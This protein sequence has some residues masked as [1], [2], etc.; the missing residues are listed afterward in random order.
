MSETPA[1]PKARGR[2]ARLLRGTLRWVIRLGLLL[3]IAVM[4]LYLARRAVLER[5]L[6]DWAETLL[7]E[8]LDAE[9][10]LGSLGGNWV[11]TFRLRGV[12]IAGRGPHAL[13][14][15]D[16]AIDLAIS[17]DAAYAEDW[18]RLVHSAQIRAKRALVTLPDPDPAADQADPTAPFV[19]D[20]V[21]QV[22]E[23][24][25][26]GGVSVTV[27]DCAL[28]RLEGSGARSTDEDPNEDTG[29]VHRGALELTLS[30]LAPRRRLDL[31]WGDIRIDASARAATRALHAELS[32]PRPGE[33]AAVFV[34]LPRPLLGGALNATL[35]LDGR[36]HLDA[37]L[38]VAGVELVGRGEVSAD[39]AVTITPGDR[40]EIDHAAVRIPGGRIDARNVGFD[41]PRTTPDLSAFL[42]RFDGALD[43]DIPDCRRFADLLPPDVAPWLPRSG[44]IRGS[45]SEHALRLENGH[46]TWPDRG[47]TAAIRGGTIPFRSRAPSA[48]GGRFGLDGP[49]RLGLRVTASEPAEFALPGDIEPLVIQG[50]ADLEV[51]GSIEVWR[52]VGSVDL[53]PGSCADQSWV[54][55]TGRIEIDPEIAPLFDLQITEAVSGSHG[56]ALGPVTLTG[57]GGLTTS[58]FSIHV[59]VDAREVAPP[60]RHVDERTPLSLTGDITWSDNSLTGTDLV[61]S[62]PADARATFALD[63]AADTLDLD[64]TEL[65]VQ[66]ARLNPVFHAEWPV[67]RIRG[68]ART[69]GQLFD[70]QIELDL[71]AVVPEPLTQVPTE[72]WH[73]AL[74]V[75]AEDQLEVALAIERAGPGAALV[76]RTATAHFGSGVEFECSGKVPVGWDGT[77]LAPLEPAPDSEP[78]RLT[79][80]LVVRGLIPAEYSISPPLPLGASTVPDETA[81]ADPESEQERFAVTAAL[82]WG[83]E[84]LAIETIDI[85]GDVAGREQSLHGNLTLA[86]LTR[87]LV[88]QLAFGEVIP[89]G[90]LT[91]API[92][93]E[94]LP[95]VLHGLP[96]LTGRMEIDAKF[97]GSL[98][99]PIESASIR[100]VDGR[101][102]TS[103][104]V[105]TIEEIQ[106][107]VDIR[108]DG[109]HIGQA[110]GSLGAG[111]FSV[112]GGAS[113]AGG[114]V[115]DAISTGR[116]LDVDV[117]IEG[118]DL[119]VLRRTGLKLRADTDVRIHGDLETLA[120]EGR[121]ALSSGTL[122]QRFSLVPDFRSRGAGTSTGITLPTIPDPFGSHVKYDVEIVTD[123]PFAIF[124]HVV[125]TK[126]RA[127]ARL[128]GTG[129][130]PRIEGTA[131]ALDGVV[132]LPAMS[133][134]VQQALITFDPDRPRFPKLFALARGRRLGVDVQAQVEGSL[135]RM[136]VELSST[137]ALSSEEITVLLSTGR[138]P[139]DLRERGLQSQ[140]ALVG[141]YLA[142]ELVDFYLGSDTTERDETLLDRFSFESGREVSRNGVESITVEFDMRSGFFLQAERDL[143]EDYNMGVL[144]RFRF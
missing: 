112:T 90:A 133:L 10:T 70:P 89:S 56:L 115:I 131:S 9:V 127:N 125:E 47:V 84:T 11:D 75:G 16:A 96:V 57:A 83:P 20:S 26:T 35:R 6:L 104:V 27:E 42:A 64:A 72:T 13:Q 55:V 130:A 61:L 94:T 69:K 2:L 71:T 68:S 44:Q 65:D 18:M 117:R 102:K 113:A 134:K 43:V 51:T 19:P 12:T 138:L 32:A 121:V 109:V 101:C 21:W 22:L 141:T 137:P 8:A 143:Y 4:G 118:D 129:S 38:R 78:P 79:G 92:D 53:G 17:L 59:T 33:I 120:V 77:K 23:T 126:I 114:S 3:V 86:G 45:F 93:L 107:A 85:T 100:I 37:A 63:L 50:S 49:A 82:D 87:A 62:G 46:L 144:Y 36:G 108:N 60:E 73:S 136:E 98:T 54:A 110:T 7:E 142:Q 97:G 40:W 66:L 58:P 119:L 48:G 123:E 122:V 88:G 14:V 106:L 1:Q 116:G 52:A 80:R 91:G 29:A 28:R 5:P 24:V 128:R 95:R 41:D 135:D 31:R 30:A 74:G 67:A 140:A 81:G 39:A 124:C 103:D 25:A 132:R 15:D 111:K 76:V 34:P 139:D 105:P 99:M